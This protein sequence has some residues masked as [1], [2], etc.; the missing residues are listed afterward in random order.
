MPVHRICSRSLFF[1][2]LSVAFHTKVMAMKLEEVKELR[3]LCTLFDSGQ[4]RK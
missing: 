4:R 2:T 3:P 1:G